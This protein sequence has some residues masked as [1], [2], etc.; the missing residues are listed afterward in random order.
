VLHKKGRKFLDQLSYSQ[1]LKIYCVLYDIGDPE[2]I[3]IAKELWLI[4][5]KSKRF[6]FSLKLADWL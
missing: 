6:F 3:R 1:L 5:G 4:S 2:S